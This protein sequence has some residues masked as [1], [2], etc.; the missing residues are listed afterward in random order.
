MNG[1]AKKIEKG[2]RRT[3]WLPNDLDKIVEDARIRLGMS[4]SGFYR[5]AIIRILENL[6]I[7]SSK[8]H[9]VGEK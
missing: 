4:R 1:V 8:A 9:E 3:F 2:I 7:L 6:S 5:Y